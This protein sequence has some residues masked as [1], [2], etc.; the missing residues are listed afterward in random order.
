MLELR[1]PRGEL[2]FSTSQRQPLSTEGNLTQA[3]TI[4]DTANNLL[5]TFDVRDPE[6]LRFPDT[7]PCCNK[8]ANIGMVNRV[9]W[10]NHVH[11]NVGGP[12]TST[13]RINAALQLRHHSQQWCQPIRLEP[14]LHLLH[15]GGIDG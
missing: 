5:T 13:G 7:G 10:S 4:L 2:P 9:H 1:L 11:R 6:S 15:F 3:L 14:E 12:G 8:L